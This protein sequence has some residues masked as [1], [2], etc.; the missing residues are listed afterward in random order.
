MVSSIYGANRT[1]NGT[2]KT[3]VGKVA[4]NLGRSPSGSSFTSNI[5]Y[6]MLTIFRS[7]LG[8]VKWR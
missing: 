8:R 7:P 5:P 2:N 3:M 6:C 1:A 4:Q